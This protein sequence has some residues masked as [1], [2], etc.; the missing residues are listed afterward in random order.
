MALSGSYADEFEQAFDIARRVQTSAGG[1]RSFR[2]R[3]PELEI[4]DAREIWSRVWPRAERVSYFV[5]ANAGSFVSK[6]KLD[7]PESGDSLLVSF[8][9]IFTSDSGDIHEQIF[10]TTVPIEKRI[11]ATRENAYNEMIKGLRD[12]YFEGDL[13]SNASRHIMGLNVVQVKCLSGGRG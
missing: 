4:D 12:R 11:G 5:E 7:C 2:R 9:V 10:H 8:Q 1:F 13:L 6:T 3:F